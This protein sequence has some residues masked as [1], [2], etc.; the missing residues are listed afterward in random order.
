MGDARTGGDLTQH[1][2]GAYILYP[3]LPNTQSGNECRVYLRI[4]DDDE[5]RWHTKYIDCRLNAAFPATQRLIIDQGRQLLRDLN[6]RPDLAGFHFSSQLSGSALVLWANLTDKRKA[7]KER[8]TDLGAELGLGRGFFRT[9][10]SPSLDARIVYPCFSIPEAF[11]WYSFAGMDEDNVLGGPGYIAVHPPRPRMPSEPED[12]R[13]SLEDLLRAVVDD[14][15]CCID[16]ETY[17]WDKQGAKEGISGVVLTTNKPHLPNIIFTLFDVGV[18][19]V[20]GYRVIPFR[21]HAHLQELLLGTIREIDPLSIVG[22]HLAFDLKRLREWLPAFN[23][24]I[25]ENGPSC[26]TAAG[27]TKAWQVPGVPIIDLYTKFTDELPPLPNKKLGTVLHHFTGE[28]GKLFDYHELAS[29][30]RK[31]EENPDDE[32]AKTGILDIL[33]YTGNDGDR[34]M[35]LFVDQVDEIVVDAIASGNRFERVCKSM[36]AIAD[37]SWEI[38]RATSHG[39]P[40]PRRAYRERAKPDLEMRR[41]MGLP[42][43]MKAVK[44]AIAGEEVV[45]EVDWDNALPRRHG[46][47][48]E[49]SLFFPALLLRGFK[50]LYDVHDDLRA[51]WH[52]YEEKSH[53]KRYRGLRKLQEYMVLPWMSYDGFCTM[54]GLRQD[55]R[56]PDDVLS[57]SAEL[58]G[59]EVPFEWANRTF[60]RSF[61][62][63]KVGLVEV[64]DS[65]VDRVNNWREAVG[66]LSEEWL[67]NYDSHFLA[68]TPEVAR[69]LEGRLLGIEVAHGPAISIADESSASKVEARCFLYDGRTIYPLRSK[70]T[71]GDT[72]KFE[73][74]TLFALLEEALQRVGEKGTLS[75]DD[76]VALRA[77]L[78]ERFCAIGTYP[79]SRL[80]I[81]RSYSIEKELARRDRERAAATLHEQMDPAETAPHH[82]FRGIPDDLLRADP[83]YGEWR[84]GFVVGLTPEEKHGV[85]VHTFLQDPRQVDGAAYKAHFEQRYASTLDWLLK[86]RGINRTLF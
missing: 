17:G 64:N 47:F 41:Y 80:V 79:R 84:H 27:Q 9:D 6:T 43:R 33:R 59:K 13:P 48:Q 53:A 63:G 14:V 1:G 73:Q 65:F 62:N 25:D 77:M 29:R 68:V 19:E 8:L 70:L 85:N 49:A 57:H 28:G 11:G 74:E 18:D 72:S 86:R 67:I 34:E 10:F 44:R 71:S 50:P 51:L 75:L 31:F 2:L 55:E 23:I 40:G 81:E 20:G 22:Y 46:E 83:R 5:E 26:L 69:S 21:N 15:H 36:R 66:G 78:D 58:R 30:V 45:P 38:K 76:S 42:L 54:F 32:Q 4:R 61:G 37:E 60:A 56:F 12:W 16:V 39:T 24:G 3:R 7:Y 82:V 52:Y 35:W